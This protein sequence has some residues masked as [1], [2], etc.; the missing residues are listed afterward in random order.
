MPLLTWENLHAPSAG[1]KKV[2][3]VAALKVADDADP[4]P[5]EPNRRL[6]ESEKN[7]LAAWAAAGAPRGEDNCETPTHSQT[8]LAVSCTPNL[9][10]SPTSEWEMPADTGD[11]Y[12]CWGVDLARDP[13]T[14]ITAFVP[15]VDNTRIAHHIVLYE[16]DAA[17]SGTPT[18]CSAS[19]SIS[20]RMVLGWAP[21]ARGLELPPEVGFPISTNPEKPTHYVVQ[22][23]YSNPQKLSG[24]KDKSRI[25]LCTS[26]PRKYEADVLA[27]GSQD[28]KIPAAPPQGG[29]YTIDCS[30]TVPLAFSGLRLFAAMPHMHK[31][32]V[33]MST[34]LVPKE[35]GGE[36]DLGTEANF[37]FDRQAWHALDATTKEGDVIRTR[38]SWV[39]NTGVEVGFGE[40]TADEMCYSFTMYYPRIESPLWSWAAPAL[41]PPIGATCHA[42]P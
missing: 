5:P 11:E 12:V 23:H 18:P 37:S 1:S 32:G 30:L 38:C 33:A 42:A 6:S 22:M 25:E 24:E 16:S 13:A 14:H 20:W 35:G 21:G 4:M 10:L 31:L 41:G 15:R 26:S 8:P 9:T 40:N 36:V 3:E 2:Y 34:T 29:R 39:N 17:Y 28:F 27:F 7:V 19:A